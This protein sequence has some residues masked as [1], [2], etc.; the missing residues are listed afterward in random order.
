M[1]V[2]A[3]FALPNADQHGLMMFWASAAMSIGL[4]VGEQFI[5]WVYAKR[6]V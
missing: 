1:S 4:F 3:C 5:Y 6:I 2:G